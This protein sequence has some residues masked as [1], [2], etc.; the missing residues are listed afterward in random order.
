MPKKAEFF[1]AAII[2]KRKGGVFLFENK[3]ELSVWFRSIQMYFL[4]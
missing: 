3:D 2:V 4:N 1:H